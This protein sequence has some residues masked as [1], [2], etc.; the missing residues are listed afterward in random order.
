MLVLYTLD[1]KERINMAEAM[2]FR[3]ALCSLN[4]DKNIE[5]DNV[6]YDLESLRNAFTHNRY[7][8][9]TKDGEDYYYIYDDKS[10]LADP[11]NA[12][13]H[14]YIKKETLYKI[15]DTIRNNYNRGLT[16]TRHK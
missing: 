16:R 2:L 13:Y 6:I 14:E 9:Y 11:N 4:N 3:Y 8:C 7:F 1:S 15:V 12:N 10:N 5:I